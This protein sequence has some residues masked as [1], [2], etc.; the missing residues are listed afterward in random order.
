MGLRIS[1]I[2][3]VFNRQE[4]L[5]RALRSIERQT[6]AVHQVI[7]VDDGSTDATADVVRNQF[8]NFE[9]L[10]QPN[11]GVSSARN[12]GVQA[13]TGD[14]VALLD[15]DDEWLPQKIEHQ[16][17]ALLQAPQMRLCHTDEI[18]VRNGVR[19][20]PMKKHQK[21]GGHIFEHCLP[22]CCMSPSS[23][24]MRRDVFEETGLFDEALPACEDYDY[25]LR[26]CAEHPVLYLDEPLLKK[27][28]GHDDQLSRKYWGMDRFRIKAMEKLLGAGKLQEDQ[29]ILVQRTLR[30]KAQVYAQGA[31]K[32][33]RIEEASRYEAKA[34]GVQT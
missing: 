26:F 23:V 15:S 20:N 3:P 4:L 11:R 32:R 25:W 14:W 5:G 12:A 21:R 2:V 22:L 27:Y 7:V 28:G 29:R 10:Q 17:R 18:W 9:L 6:A 24:V 33:G 16:T 8:P 34:E 30:H 19:V 1:V 13:A 31:R